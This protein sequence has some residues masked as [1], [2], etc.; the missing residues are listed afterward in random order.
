MA[1]YQLQS[2]Y[3]QIH[4]PQEEEEKVIKRWEM[5]K[6]NKKAKH[7]TVVRGLG[8]LGEGDPL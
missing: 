2:L 8:S 3:N 5:V 4:L 7:T 6:K 1:S